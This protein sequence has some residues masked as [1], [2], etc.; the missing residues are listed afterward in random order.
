[1]G[2]QAN[3]APEAVSPVPS[4]E[5]QP[6]HVSPDS[7]TNEDKKPLPTTDVLQ[8]LQAAGGSVSFTLEEEKKVL[9]KIDLRVLPFMLGAYFLQQCDKAALGNTAVFGLRD[10]THLHGTQYSWLGSILYLAQLIFQPLGAFLLVKLPLGKVIGVAIVLWAVSLFGMAGS[11][12]F[13]GLATTRFLLGAFESI[14]GESGLPIFFPFS[15]E[16]H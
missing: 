8:V 2:A 16:G 10:Q 5:H 6:A 14:I 12:N 4:Q 7:L 1:M 3:N 15:I 9:R 13:A 11:R